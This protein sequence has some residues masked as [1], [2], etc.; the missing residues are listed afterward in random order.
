MLQHVGLSHWTRKH[1]AC[2]VFQK[3]TAPLDFEKY[4]DRKGIGTQHLIGVDCVD[5]ECLKEFSFLSLPAWRTEIRIYQCAS[6]EW[7]PIF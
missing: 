1:S 2:Q 6:N 4:L 7:I 5:V 3:S